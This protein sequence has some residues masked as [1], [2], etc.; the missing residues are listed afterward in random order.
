MIFPTVTVFIVS[1]VAQTFMNQMN[2]FSMYGAGAPDINIYTIGYYLYTHVLG[3]TLSDYP[4]YSA[5][6]LVLTFIT[7]PVAFITKFLLE[8]F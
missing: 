8:K 2:V 7:V 6:G 5:F 3:A 1:S 4:Y